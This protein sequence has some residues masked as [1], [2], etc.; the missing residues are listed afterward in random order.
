[1]IQYAIMGFELQK[2][3]QREMDTRIPRGPRGSLQNEL[4]SRFYFFRSQRIPFE[5]SLTKAVG[6]IKEHH[7]DFEP[8]ILRTL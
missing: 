5:V 7:P 6:G 8:K 4:R 2:G 1:V 3:I